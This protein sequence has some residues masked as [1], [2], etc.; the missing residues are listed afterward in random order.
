MS[1]KYPIIIKFVFPLTTFYPSGAQKSN[2]YKRDVFVTQWRFHNRAWQRQ[3]HDCLP[4][5]SGTLWI[6]RGA[7]TNQQCSLA[8]GCGVKYW[9]KQYANVPATI[10]TRTRNYHDV[11]IPSILHLWNKCSLLCG[12]HQRVYR[13]CTRLCLFASGLPCAT[14]SSSWL[15]CVVIWLT[16]L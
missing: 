14:E 3:S 11:E 5:S 16:I 13:T 7:L 1:K 10:I 6:H 12:R 4:E 15:N 8:T 2:V 9:S